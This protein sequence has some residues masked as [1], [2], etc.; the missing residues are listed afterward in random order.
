MPSM[1][2]MVERSNYKFNRENIGDVNADWLAPG[3]SLAQAAQSAGIAETD[4]DM[5]YLN[6]LPPGLQ[7]VIRAA[8]YSAVTR[9]LPVTLAWAPAFDFSVSVWDVAST[10]QS[11]GG[12]TLLIRGPYQRSTAS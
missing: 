4:A 8:L 6:A 1:Q 3:V 11:V 5:Q 7:E 10:V 12:M 9:E 2:A